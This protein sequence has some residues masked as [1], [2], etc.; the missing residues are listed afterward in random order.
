[1]GRIVRRLTDADKA[2]IVQLWPTCSLA[3]IARRMGRAPSAVH[4]HAKAQGLPPKGRAAAD[5][6]AAEDDVM[7]ARFATT[8]VPVLAAELGRTRGAVA[9]RAIILG[10]RKDGDYLRRMRVRQCQVIRRA[11]GSWGTSA[12]DFALPVGAG[13]IGAG[14]MAADF[15]RRFCP[16]SRCDAAGKYDPRGR[17]WRIGDAVLA[18]ADIIAR[19]TRKGWVRG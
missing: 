8:P 9:T 11:R 7:R 10:L 5:W 19:A 4:S 1:M 17:Y 3:E 12:A 18:E 16:V 13:A 2:T 6:S 15:L 14:A